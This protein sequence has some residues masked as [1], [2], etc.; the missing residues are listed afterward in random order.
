MPTSPLAPTLPACVTVVICA[1]CGTHPFTAA[2]DNTFHCPCGSCITARDIDLDGETVWCVTPAGH[3]AFLP[4]P[5][6]VW[7]RYVQARTVMED[8]GQWGPALDDAHRAFLQALAELNAARTLGVPLP[9]FGDV[10]IGRVYLACVLN[11][12]GT[13][14]DSNAYGLGWE[15]EACA[16]RATD[17]HF[18]KRYPC[19]NPR[20]HAWRQVTDWEQNVNGRDH[21]QYVVLSPLAPDLVTAR[22]K[23]AETCAA[24]AAVRAA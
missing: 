24:R 18:Q 4:D 7:E 8:P 15:C 5:A 21:E 1:E 6:A 14:S 23:A 20:G 12:D 17:P 13:L 16:P 2:P 22:G 9:A 10:Q 3:V 19:R 11:A